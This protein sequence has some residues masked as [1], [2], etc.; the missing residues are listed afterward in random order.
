MMTLSFRESAV[1]GLV[2]PASADETS[3]PVAAN[4]VPRRAALPNISRRVIGF[5]AHSGNAEATRIEAK[6]R[7]WR[8]AKSDY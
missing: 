4:A 5:I 8:G 2:V 1:E 7:E 3:G 6:S